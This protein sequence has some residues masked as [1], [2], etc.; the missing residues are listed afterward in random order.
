MNLYSV[1]AAACEGEAL[2]LVG[3]SPRGLGGEAWRVLSRRFDGAGAARRCSALV[4]LLNPGRVSLDRLGSHVAQW[5]E[6]LRMYEARAGAPLA[7]IRTVALHSM[8][9]EPLYTHLALNSARLTTFALM[10]E[11]VERF[12]ENHTAGAAA[13]ARG[14]APMDLLLG[15]EGCGEGRRFDPKVGRRGK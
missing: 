11:E 4:A 12:L 13:G 2:D 14:P 3:A 7:D 1:L 15:H 5:H 9:P 10:R 8:T 6:Q